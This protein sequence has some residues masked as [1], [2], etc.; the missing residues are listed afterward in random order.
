MTRYVILFFNL[1]QQLFASKRGVWG[2]TSK[3]ALALYIF[4]LGLMHI[5]KYVSVHAT[6]IQNAV[7][8]H[9]IDFLLVRRVLQ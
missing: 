4:Y 6:Q 5:I 9:S 8:T 2:I 3:R 1:T 7:E